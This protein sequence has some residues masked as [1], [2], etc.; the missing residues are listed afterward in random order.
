MKSVMTGVSV[1]EAVNA[2]IPVLRM[3]SR[4][5]PAIALLL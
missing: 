4:I 1:S 3:E 2:V 5:S